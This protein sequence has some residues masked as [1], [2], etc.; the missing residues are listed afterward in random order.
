MNNRII[1]FILASLLLSLVHAQ[2]KALDAYFKQVKAGK[3]PSIPHEITKPE[4]AAAVLK[5]LPVYYKDTTALVRSKA[6]SLTKTIGT[7]SQ[8]RTIRHEA[9]KQLIEGGKD[10]NTG[11]AGAA[12]KYLTLFKQE[13]FVTASKDSLR[14]QFIRNPRHVDVK[15]KLI[16]F[17]DMRELRDEVYSLSQ[18]STLGR[19]ERWSA[20]LAL[21]RMGDVQAT[22]DIVNRVKRMP[23]S[24]ALVYEIYP[25]LMYTR[26]QEAMELLLVTLNSD[27][28]NCSAADAERDAKIPC[29][30]RVMEM[31]ATVLENYPLT[32]DESG[33]IQTSNY[34]E[35]LRTAREW[36]STQ[37]TFTIRKDTF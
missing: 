23:E 34:P 8:D 18:Q 10:V 7:K 17:L 35:A 30:Y 15:V 9:V 13:D 33:D 24:D 2:P 3:H 11:N 29:A 16:G 25:D 1:I 20:S 6:Y 27:A 19:K 14:S 26:T 5:A 31:L 21:A 22:A 36:C 37:K 4:N 12:L 28:K 32:V